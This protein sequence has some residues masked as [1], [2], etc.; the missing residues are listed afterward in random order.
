MKTKEANTPERIHKAYTAEM[1]VEPGERA[2]IAKISTIDVDRDGDVMIPQGMDATE[3]LKNPIVFWNHDYDK[4]VAKCAKLWRD[5]SAV[6]AKDI[7][8]PRPE[9]HEGEWLPDTVFG[10][11]QAGVVKG[12]SIGFDPRQSV[13]RTPNKKDLEDYGPDVRRVYSRWKKLEHSVAPMQCNQ[14][15][16]VVAVSKGLVSADAAKKL[17]GYEAK[18]DAPIEEEKKEDDKPPMGTCSGCGKEYPIADMT[19]EDGKYT[20]AECGA[21]KEAPEDEGKAIEMVVSAVSMP[22]TKA[23]DVPTEE[24]VYRELDGPEPEDRNTM[25]RQ[26]VTVEVAKRQGRAYLR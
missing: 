11:I 3:F 24:I 1:T 9:G 14:E 15:A 16:L 21:K 7:Y 23:L 8:P 6:Y 17:L 20:C 25:V 2:V 19:E 4:P 12:T 26:L 5:D 13:A 10:L 18:S 22:E